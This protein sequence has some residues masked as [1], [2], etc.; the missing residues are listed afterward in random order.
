[1]CYWKGYWIIK[2]DCTDCYNGLH[3]IKVMKS[4]SLDLHMCF[5]PQDV[6]LKVKRATGTFSIV[7]WWVESLHFVFVLKWH[8]SIFNFIKISCVALS[9]CLRYGCSVSLTLW[10]RYSYVQMFVCFFKLI[11]LPS[12]NE[13]NVLKVTI[14]THNQKNNK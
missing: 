2:A 14:K 6:L 8:L 1:M 4:F 13:L 3:G 9:C 5:N 12:K 7:A 10:L 11:L